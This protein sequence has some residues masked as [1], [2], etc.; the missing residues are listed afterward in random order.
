MAS[1][2]AIP[3]ELLVLILEHVGGR[4]LRR[5]ETGKPA[6]Y[7]RGWRATE[8]LALCRE[9]YAA[10]RPVYLSGLHVSEMRLYA[11]SLR[12]PDHDFGHSR[13]RKLMYKNTR[14]L[15]L[16][17]LGHFWDTRSAEDN[18]RWHAEDGWTG[19]FAENEPP[20]NFEWDSA[21]GRTTL[22]E[23]RDKTIRTR[24]DELFEDLRHFTV[25]K[26]LD[27][28]ASSDPDGIGPDWDYIHL[29]TISKLV[30]NLPIMHSLR[31]FILDT[32]GTRLNGDDGSV[33]ICEQIA[34]ILPHIENVRLRMITICPAIFN[35]RSR[36]STRKVALKT[37]IV[38]LHLPSG[39]Q[40]TALQESE[41]CVQMRASL[42]PQTAHYAH[43]V[44][45]TPM[46]LERLSTL[47]DLSNDSVAQG[48]GVTGCMISYRLAENIWTYNCIARERI[49][50]RGYPFHEYDDG[51][52]CWVE[53]QGGR[54]IRSDDGNTR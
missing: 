8:K 18:E 53:L 29:A 36:P 54:A 10:A 41:P 46:L 24:L 33:H 26:Y 21:N 25:L 51:K 16:R 11:C 47:R 45:A 13:S 12:S 17:L 19:P 22:R 39:F 2:M 52:P 28:T 50:L 34:E 3:A 6:R 14:S 1:L 48:H 27:I 23:W 37:L 38:K 49:S 9:W 30:M 44:C 40:H 31:T 7:S 15:S 4:E 32:S 42:A 43:M 20:E 5:S 35:I